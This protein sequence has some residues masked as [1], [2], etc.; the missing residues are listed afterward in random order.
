M[1]TIDL[2]SKGETVAALPRR[3]SLSLRRLF[4]TR[5]TWN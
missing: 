1:G 4:R 3:G 5:D 2:G